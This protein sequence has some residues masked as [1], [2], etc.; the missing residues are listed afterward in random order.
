MTWLSFI[1]FNHA[2][3]ALGLGLDHGHATFSSFGLNQ[4]ICHDFDG[5]SNKWNKK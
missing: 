3:L 5:I 2:V 4:L 1:L